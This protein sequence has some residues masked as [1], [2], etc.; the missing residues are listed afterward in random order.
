MANSHPTSYVMR[1]VPVWKIVEEQRKDG[2]GWKWVEI[3]RDDIEPRGGQ[4]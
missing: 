4:L 1:E 2:R 3:S